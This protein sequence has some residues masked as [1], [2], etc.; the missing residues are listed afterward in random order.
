MSFQ[1]SYARGFALS[2]GII[3]KHLSAF[4]VWYFQRRQ[5]AQD[6][7]QATP[8]CECLLEARVGSEA[9]QS[10]FGGIHT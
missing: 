10:F 2:E 6:A 3:P 7:L 4:L 8:R 5:A 1:V 9:W